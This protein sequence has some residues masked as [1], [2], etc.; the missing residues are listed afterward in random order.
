MNF[1]S[2]C[3]RVVLESG[4][5]NSGPSSID[6][7]KGDM[8]R[9][10]NWVNNAWFELQAKRNQW[11]WMRK[12]A[13]VGI[14]KGE[15]QINLPSDFKSIVCGTLFVDGRKLFE[16]KALTDGDQ[17][18][19]S[20]PQS[21][22]YDLDGSLKLSSVPDFDYSLSLWYYVKPSHLI[23]GTDSPLLP[24][25]YHMMIVWDALREY[26]IF[27]EAPELYQKAEKNYKTLLYRLENSFLPPFQLAGPLA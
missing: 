17:A 7:Q 25:E 10:I 12:K 9:M 23:N 1:L 27:D 2:L 20:P 21:F 3:Q 26:A 4:I 19:V 16:S 6:S 11:Q 13:T 18:S 14:R 15:K 22:Y 5:S 8:Q 24:E